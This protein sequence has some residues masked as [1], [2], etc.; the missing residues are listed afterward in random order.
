MQIELRQIGKKFNSEWI[1]R[2]LDYLFE[3]QKT[4][5][6]LGRN[7]SGKSTLLQVIAGSMSPNA[8]TAAYTLSGKPVT[9][10]SV[11][12]Y[13]VL[14]APYQQLI[15][16]FTLNEMISFHFSFKSYLKG[17]DRSKII[18]LMQLA[19]NR[20]KPLL[21]FSSGMKQRVKL[22]LA[23]C[24]EVPLIL[25]DE[26]TMNLDKGGMTWYFQ[27]MDD[28]GKN[29]TTIICTNQ[30]ETEAPFAH[31]ILTIEQFRQ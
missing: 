29:R 21:Q 3:A 4:T 7:G 9:Q 26:P 20:D 18:D 11:Y 17:F 27:L 5:A 19:G 25:L 31:S 8:G 12:R 24:S 15:E 22:A 30:Q 28:L 23:L 13:L 2:K 1:F 6:I 16:E 14:V 10:E